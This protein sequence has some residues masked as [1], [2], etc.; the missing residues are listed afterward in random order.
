MWR[1]TRVLFLVG[2]L[3]ASAAQAYILPHWSILRRASD[4]RDELQLANLRVDG[5][6]TFFGPAAK[7][8]ASAF[9]ISSD[10]LEL[11]TDGVIYLK[12]PGRC[13]AEA[14]PLEG[15]QRS[16]VVAA[17]GR[18]RIEGKQ[19]VPLRAAIDQI[20]PL[21]A[22]RSGAEGEVR[23]LLEQH[24]GELGVS[25]RRTSLARFGGQVAFVLGEPGE[26]KPQFWVYKDSFHPA[27]LRFSDA[28]GISWDIRFLRFGSPATG[29][30]FPRTLEVFRQG[31]LLARFTALKADGRTRLDDKL[32]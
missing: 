17:H 20:C 2:V 29:D 23:A 30:W 22:S 28:Q 8:A 11:Q 21:L 7:E 16:V 3:A 13:R 15:E 31:E 19:I 32:F 1:G 12:L 26:E 24:L 27:R 18:K 4:K 25:Y 9:E 14:S 6:F 10:R 5:S